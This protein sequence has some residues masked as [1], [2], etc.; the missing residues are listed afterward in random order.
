MK[1]EKKEMGSPSPP[2]LPS[3]HSDHMTCAGRNELNPISA[4]AGLKG[5]KPTGG[6]VAFYYVSGTV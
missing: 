5:R 6:D 1:G 4:A 3:P 2:L